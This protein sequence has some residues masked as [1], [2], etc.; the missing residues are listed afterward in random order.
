MLMAED[1]KIQF[2]QNFNVGSHLDMLID[3]M[4]STI[5]SVLESSINFREMGSLCV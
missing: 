5:D 1:L 2:F 4:H 3:S